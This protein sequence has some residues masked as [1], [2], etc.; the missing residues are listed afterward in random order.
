MTKKRIRE[1]KDKSRLTRNFALQFAIDSASGTSD[2]ET[3][4]FSFLRC[5]KAFTPR[6]ETSVAVQ[7]K[8]KLQRIDKAA[9]PAPAALRQAAESM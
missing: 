4:F 1:K 2:I 9:R 8:N 6:D 3:F 5:A 7:E